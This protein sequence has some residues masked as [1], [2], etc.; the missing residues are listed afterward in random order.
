MTSCGRR[1]NDGTLECRQANHCYETAELLTPEICREALR[2]FWDDQTDVAE[3]SEG[4]ADVSALERQLDELVPALE[5]L[6]PEEI[7]IVEKSAG[8]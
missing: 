4:V 7:K 5:G 3:T 6:T 2:R 8:K 1:T